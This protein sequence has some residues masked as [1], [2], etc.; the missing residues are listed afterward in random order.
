M[1]TGL[2]VDCATGEESIEEVDLP[3]SPVPASVSPLQIRRALRSAGL[4]TA[5]N[6][7]VAAQDDEVQEA[8]EY[9]TVIL[10]DHQVIADGTTALEMTT[11][12]VNDLFRLAA[13][14]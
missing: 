12:Q 6:A 5:V 11:E 3:P 9:A 14:L 7:F 8:W 1:A 10:R 4:L 13:T 2:I